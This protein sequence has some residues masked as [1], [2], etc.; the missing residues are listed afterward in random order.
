M[1]QID[2]KRRYVDKARYFRAMGFF[3][4]YSSLSDEEMASRI[5]D[6]VRRLWDEPCPAG[7][8]KDLQ[9]ADMYM[10]ATDKGRVWQGDLEFVYPGENGYA[11]FLSELAA[12][13]RTAFKP[14]DISE[15]WKG[16]RGPVDVVFDV[17]GKRFSFIHRGGD[18]LDPSIVR[19]INGA[20]KDSGI[21]FEAC[22]NFGMPNFIVAL[23]REEREKLA[24]RGWTF[25]P[26][27]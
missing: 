23:T 19:T 24:A 17:N 3:V 18:M 1:E 14:R 13:S 20:I 8:E 5:L 11:Q 9:L 25:W 10:L 6:D 4:K 2:L 26:G 27:T 15:K 22:D 21:R 12:I 16:E 7:S